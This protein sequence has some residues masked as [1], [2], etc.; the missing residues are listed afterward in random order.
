V[1]LD[2]ILACYLVAGKA[3]EKSSLLPLTMEAA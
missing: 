2:D 3:L 1:T